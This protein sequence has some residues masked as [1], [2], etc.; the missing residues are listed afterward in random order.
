MHLRHIGSG[1][2]E[3][4]QTQEQGGQAGGMSICMDE[5]KAHPKLIL[6]THVVPDRWLLQGGTVGAGGV[7]RWFRRGAGSGFE[8]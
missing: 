6:G 8:L 1:G 3:A 5:A 4:G 7:L 2:V